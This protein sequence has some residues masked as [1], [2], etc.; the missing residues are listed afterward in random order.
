MKFLKLSKNHSCEITYPKDVLVGKN[1]DGINQV[2][3]L[4]EIQDDDLILDIGPKTLNKIKTLLK[5]V[6][7][8]YGMVQQVILRTQILQMV[9]MKLLKQ[10]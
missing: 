9:V 8:S 6:K 7:L 5:L 10:L 3:E 1:M 4:N 2:K